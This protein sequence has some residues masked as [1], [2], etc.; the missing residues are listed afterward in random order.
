MILNAR[1]SINLFQLL[2]QNYNQILM[3]ALLH[4]K[5]VSIQ[6]TYDLWN[7]DSV[8][9]VQ[10]LRRCGSSASGRAFNIPYFF[11]FCKIL[12]LVERM[13][14][15]VMPMMWRTALSSMP[16]SQRMRKKVLWAVFG[17]YFFWMRQKA[18]KSMALQQ[19]MKHLQS[20]FDQPDVVPFFLTSSQSSLP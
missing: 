6:E 11:P 19:S 2:S 15:C 17:A 13:A 1:S 3:I 4:C 7:K 8:I 18:G 10:T 16:I 5:N 14:S 20:S 12:Y 9:T